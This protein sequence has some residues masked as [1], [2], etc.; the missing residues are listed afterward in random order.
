MHRRRYSTDIKFDNRQIASIT[1]N[2]EHDNKLVF[3]NIICLYCLHFNSHVYAYVCILYKYIVLSA[4]KRLHFRLCGNNL[5]LH[6][7]FNGRNRDL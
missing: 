1:N 3:E 7:H 2:N 5:K 4:F 6:V